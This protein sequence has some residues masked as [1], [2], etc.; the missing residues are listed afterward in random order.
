VR[1]LG[2]DGSEMF[3]LYLVGFGLG[4]GMG[5]YRELHINNTEWGGYLLLK[6]DCYNCLIIS[7]VI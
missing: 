5:L 2:F 4:G 1:G 6:E 3:C 7:L